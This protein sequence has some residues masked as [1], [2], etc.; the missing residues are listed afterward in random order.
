MLF[1]FLTVRL[2]PFSLLATLQD[3]LIPAMTAGFIKASD[4]GSVYPSAPTISKLLVNKT[5]EVNR[6]SKAAATNMLHKVVPFPS[7]KSPSG[8]TRCPVYKYL[9]RTISYFYTI[10]QKEAV[11]EFVKCV[12]ELG[13][14]VGHKVYYNNSATRYRVALTPTEAAS[15]GVNNNFLSVS[16]GWQATVAA[17]L[18]VFRRLGAGDRFSESSGTAGDPPVLVCSMAQF[19]LVVTKISE[20]LKRVG[21]IMEETTPGVNQGHRGSWL[22]MI[23]FLDDFLVKTSEARN[24]LRQLDGRSDARALVPDDSSVNPLPCGGDAG[25]DGEEEEDGGDEDAN[26]GAQ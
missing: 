19:G 7:P 8:F 14:N 13:T 11:K 17:G 10:V 26:D 21:N 9:S 2:L 25:E 5:M 6:L 22:S 12:H 23:S 24:G 15:L 4:A 18:A 20:Y 1:F 3:E 16:H